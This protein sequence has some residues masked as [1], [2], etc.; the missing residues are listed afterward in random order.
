MG[1]S[2]HSKNLQTIPEGQMAQSPVAGKS[3][4]SGLQGG[5]HLVHL[6]VHH[7]SRKVHLRVL[8]CEGLKIC[9]NPEGALFARELH[10]LSLAAES[11]AE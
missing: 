6:L 1:L 10:S 7:P 5:S 4:R 11:T 9:Q 3:V 2:G 8:F